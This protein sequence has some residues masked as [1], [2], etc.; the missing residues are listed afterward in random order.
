MRICEV[1][2]DY[3]FHCS[4]E[5]R[6]SINTVHAYKCDLK[7]FTRFALADE[8]QGVLSVA[9]IKQYLAYM[10]NDAG[11]SISTVRRR[12]ACLRG[13][14]AFAHTRHGYKDPFSEW[15]PALKRPKRL[16]RPASCNEVRALT[17][18]SC[19]IS[20]IE[21]DTIFA[22]LFLSVTGL[23]VSELCAV[24]AN[25]VS[26]D[27]TAVQVMGKGARERMV[28]ISDEGLRRDIVERRGQRIEVDGEC[29]PL[30]VNSRGG[31][32]QPQ[33]LRRRL[34]NLRE[35]NGISRTI[36]P[37]ML[38]HTAATLLI[39]SGTDIRFV[40]RLL[41]H[42]SIATTEIYTQVNDLSLK[43]AIFEANTVQL[44][45]AAQ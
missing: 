34:H 36:T 24:R 5:R 12:I 44:I 23:R 27:G 26:P 17:A 32:L 39:E 37:H 6:L 40:Q 13:F 25:D 15:S 33:S 45:L 4:V 8:A 43:R 19:E 29:A 10:L 28:Y 9:E 11:L 18:R 41:G 38:R 7:H 35:R 3:L 2:E 16:P 30:L 20:N 31:P 22:V 42:A 14:S 1:V 21:A